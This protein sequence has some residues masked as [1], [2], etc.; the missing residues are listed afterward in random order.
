MQLEHDTDAPQRVLAMN[1]GAEPDSPQDSYRFNPW[2]APGSAPVT[3][4]CGT[5]GG[6]QPWH[7]GPGDAV[8]AKTQ[9]ASFGALGSQ[10]LD[11]APSGTIWTVGGS[12]WFVAER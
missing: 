4:A 7:A 5:A 6:T 1:L 8:F 10:V 11:P 2:R 9:F 12:A 3:D